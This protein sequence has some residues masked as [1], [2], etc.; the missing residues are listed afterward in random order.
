MAKV[1][2]PSAVE[3]PQIVLLGKQYTFAET[4]Q[5]RQRRNRE[6]QQ[7]MVAIERESMTRENALRNGE[8]V[9]PNVRPEDELENAVLRLCCEVMENNLVAAE[10]LADTLWQAY[11]EALP[12]VTAEFLTR[13][14]AWVEQSRQNLETQGEALAPTV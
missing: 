6:L 13:C 4:T 1:Y 9:P 12:G 8:T 5:P 3:L 10:G 2:D 14:A 7:T 11:V